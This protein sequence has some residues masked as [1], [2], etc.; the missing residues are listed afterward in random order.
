MLKWQLD[1]E[2]AVQQAI[3]LRDDFLIHRRLMLAAPSLLRYELTNG[4]LTAFRLG[5]LPR[6]HAEDGLSNLLAA[7]IE[8]VE[9]DPA[10]I[11]SLAA[12]W[13]VSAY[14]GA[15]LAA[16]EQLDTDV[17]TGDRALYTTCRKKGSRVRW[18]GDYGQRA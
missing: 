10:Q 3:A 7:G 8:L 1:D 11:F 15:Y 2:D 6:E 13:N 5:R 18:I 4:L 12:K 16:A 9:V 17:W 14:D